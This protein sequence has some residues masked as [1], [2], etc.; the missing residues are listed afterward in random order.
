MAAV[1]QRKTFDE[2]FP[3]T[4]PADATPSLENTLVEGYVTPW[5]ALG[6][7]FEEYELWRQLAK[8][9]EWNKRWNVF[10]DSQSKWI[11]PRWNKYSNELP[12][13]HCPKLYIMPNGDALYKIAINSYSHLKTLDVW[14][15]DVIDAATDV[16]VLSQAKAAELRWYRTGPY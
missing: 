8:Q 10:S 13:Y 14:R 9:Q 12:H 11:N 15:L 6:W 5:Y 3:L 16:L 2:V 1:P 7:T 4:L